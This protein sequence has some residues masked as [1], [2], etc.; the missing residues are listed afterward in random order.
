MGHNHSHEHEHSNDSI[1]NLKIAFFLNFSFTIFEI[2]GG[3]YTNSIA[4][5]SDALHDFGDSLSLGLS[6]LLEKKSKKAGN[7]RFSFG[8]QRF[9]LLGALINSIILLIGSVLIISEAIPRILSPEKSN[10]RGMLGFA[11][12][13]ILINGLAVLRLSSSH[14]INQRVA[15]WHL[16]EDVLGWIAVLIVSIVLLFK[17]IPILDPVLSILITIYVLY[18]VLKNLKETLHI[19]LQGVPEEIDLENLEDELKKLDRIKSVHS[20]NLWSLDG[21]KHVFSVHLLVEK[22]EG[23]S[24]IILIKKQVKDL[25]LKSSIHHAT[26]E[27]EFLDEACYMQEVKKKD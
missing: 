3:L 12:A 10:A 17:D 6:I 13:G 19:F 18:N 25:L 1:K 5:L 7:F 14:S 11:I 16:L 22:L 23:I 24:D 20:L 27:I 15:M 4:I 9:S 8:Y 26:I 2:F 21:V